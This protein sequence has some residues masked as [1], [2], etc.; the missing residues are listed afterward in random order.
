M[1]SIVSSIFC[2]G[3]KKHNEIEIISNEEKEENQNQKILNEKNSN[4]NSKLNSDSNKKYSFISQKNSNLQSNE[5][6][7]KTENEISKS[8][9]IYIKDNEEH[10]IEEK[11]IDIE[12][13]NNNLSSSKNS[14]SD[15]SI[16]KNNNVNNNNLMKYKI[17]NNDIIDERN[18]KSISQ[19]SHD[20][21]ISSN[22][23]SS[24]KNFTQIFTT[25]ENSFVR[26]NSKNSKRSF[27]KNKLKNQKKKKKEI[28]L[29]FDNIILDEEI[30]LAPKL[31]ISEIN[32]S[33]L[34]NGKI[35]Y[36]NASGCNE[37]LRQKRDGM[38]FFGLNEYE[39]DEIVNDIIINLEKDIKLTKLF[40]I[41]YDRKRAHYY[42]QNLNNDVKE[43][44]FLMYIKI[45]ND[46][47]LS[48]EDTLNNYLILGRN[49]IS[50]NLDNDNDLN[51][52][53]F[54]DKNEFNRNKY[55][56]YKFN[57]SNPHIS[58]GRENCTIN[59]DNPFL[60]RVHCTFFYNKY[61]NKWR[62]CDGN[63]NKKSS[64]YGTWYILNGN[65]FELS[66]LL[67]DYEVKIG[68]QLFNIKFKDE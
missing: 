43:N 18:N 7:L 12:K 35:I 33:N 30:E 5:K 61:I 37:G 58:I 66:S 36:I 15:S 6:K 42:I 45:Y 38:T 51:I 14:I 55:K 60:S 46:Y 19:I 52:K 16:K 1:S 59:L 29:D 31:I 41:Y 4:T 47:Y 22:S 32:Q 17:F 54:E 20:D 57:S 9:I 40:V 23:S 53:I 2:C 44:K 49:L 39:K 25:E 13:L 34:F 11:E 27:I 64:T 26:K 24:I 28:N 68:E 56:E 62:L 63:G 65:K 48:N 21:N 3:R 50:F 8:N 10:K 67:Y